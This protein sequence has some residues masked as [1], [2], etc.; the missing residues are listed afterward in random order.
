[1]H[2]WAQKSRLFHSDAFKIGTICFALLC[3]SSPSVGIGHTKTHTI[4]DCVS[5]SLGGD[6]WDRI[7]DLWNA[8]QA[9]FQPSYTPAFNYPQRLRLISKQKWD[10]STNI[11]TILAIFVFG[12]FV[13]F[14]RSKGLS[15]GYCGLPAELY[16]KIRLFST[17]LW[18]YRKR[19]WKL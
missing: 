13:K 8:I 7:A 19:H 9:L 17:K 16:P 11:R 12:F 4:Y 6:N 10:F 15:T 5:S 1:M 18:I 3:G 2:F 14:C